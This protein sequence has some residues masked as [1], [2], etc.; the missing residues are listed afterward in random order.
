MMLFRP[1]KA[2]K[3]VTGAYSSPRGS[4]LY[5]QMFL[6][7]PM[8][9]IPAVLPRAEHLGSGAALLRRA[10]AFVCTTSK[11]RSLGGSVV[12]YTLACSGVLGD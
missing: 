2:Q 11:G 4:N 10:P 9:S 5:L 1:N 3:K 8:G 7:H 12:P 6:H